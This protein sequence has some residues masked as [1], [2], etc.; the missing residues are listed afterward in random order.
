[1]ASETDPSGRARALRMSLAAVMTLG[2]TIATALMFRHA[3]TSARQAARHSLCISHGKHIGLAM[4][5]TA[6]EGRWF[7][8][9]IVDDQGRP[10]LSWRVAILPR[11]GE[12]NLYDE[13]HLDEPW[14]SEHNRRLIPRMPE[15]Y[16]CPDSIMPP[17]AGLT[18]Y[19][20][21][22][23]A[24]MAFDQPKPLDDLV[25][26][27]RLTGVTRGDFTDGLSQTILVVEVAPEDAVPWTK[28]EDFGCAPA[29]T[30][31]RLFRGSAHP[32][33]LHSF[34]FASGNVQAIGP[35]VTPENLAAALTRSGGD[36]TTLD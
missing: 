32:N 33:G 24:G 35:D 34:V 36:R 17:D 6:D 18:T 29:D 7:P 13:F 4:H 14:D 2:L 21:A 20:A 22:A 19:L 11:L 5:T 28:P 10:L 15:Y 23:G 26:R 16:R 31:A 3:V 30:R 8:A 27:A 12:A 9:A 1:M 25:R